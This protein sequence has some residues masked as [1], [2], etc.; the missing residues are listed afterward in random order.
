[1]MYIWIEPNGSHSEMCKITLPWHP[2]ETNRCLIVWDLL[3]MG[4]LSLPRAGDVPGS[5]GS[6]GL[7]CWAR[8]ICV[9]CI[10]KTSH[11]I[12]AKCMVSGN[13]HF[14]GVAAIH[15]LLGL[16]LIPSRTNNQVGNEAALLLSR[17]S[18]CYTPRLYYR[19]QWMLV[20]KNLLL[21]F[22]NFSSSNY[23][24]LKCL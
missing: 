11:F 3:Q 10:F 15:P 4:N 21:A 6:I 7:L 12:L 22:L 14:W 8:F 5:Q 2:S 24:Y 19:S 18:D 17:V 13:P 23:K 9:P 20:L 1:M 16:W